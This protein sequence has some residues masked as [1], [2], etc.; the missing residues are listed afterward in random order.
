MATSSFKHQERSIFSTLTANK[1]NYFYH[2]L[3]NFILEGRAYSQGLTVQKGSAVGLILATMQKLA[4]SSVA[5]IL[6]AL[7]NRKRNFQAKKAEAEEEQAR[8]LM[9]LKEAG[10]SENELDSAEERDKEIL[11]AMI[12]V[13]RDEET[14]IDQLIGYATEVRSES[15]MEVILDLIESDHPEDS[16]LFFT[17][18]KATQG[19][20]VKLLRDKYGHQSVGFINGDNFLNIQDADQEVRLTSNRRDLAEQFNNGEVRFL[21]ST[22]KVEGVDLQR[23]CH[24]LI[25]VDMPWNPMGF[26]NVLED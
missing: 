12:K 26:T 8:M 4:A 5:V 7:R 19:L 17:E 24:V 14:S 6:S 11:A 22:E 23:N 15:K 9:L 20:L 25:Q 1:K 21:V 10:A 3:K 13:N 16:I 18:Y 2:C